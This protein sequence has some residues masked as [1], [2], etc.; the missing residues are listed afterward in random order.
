M[1]YVVT[2]FFVVVAVVSG[3]SEYS[4][5]PSAPGGPN[6]CLREGAACVRQ[7]DCC[8]MWCANGDCTHKED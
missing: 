3:C 8:S 5:D 4:K 6:A 2:A 1:R 7:N